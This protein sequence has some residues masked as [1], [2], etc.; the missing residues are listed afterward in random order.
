MSTTI[1]ETIS[2]T[3]PVI[4]DSKP[5]DGAAPKRRDL[6]TTIWHADEELHQK[7][8]AEKGGKEDMWQGGDIYYPNPPKI[9]VE[10]VIEDV[11]GREDQFTLK[12]NGFIFGK[13]YTKV[14]LKT[15]DLSDTK[16]IKEQYYPE[17][18]AWLKEVTGAPRVHVFHHGTRISSSTFHINKFDRN[19]PPQ[20]QPAVYAAHVDQ[21]SWQAKNVV[22]SHFPDECEALLH[23]RVMI[24]NAWR[25]IKP[26]YKDPFGVA[27]A[28]TVPY[29]DLVIRPNRVFKDIRE[30][31][32]LKPGKGH[33]WYY[34]F[35][36][37]PE[38]V[39]VFKGYDNHGKARACAH[40]AFVD[41]EFE[42]GPARESIELR[43]LLFWPDDESVLKE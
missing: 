4:S 38:D 21:S 13:Q 39:L 18:E 20:H 17:M 16:K 3:L 8:L 10:G 12:D 33:R 27:D 15:E 42:D 24:V 26:V 1:T 43:A 2:Q 23:G 19:A 7:Q 32:G 9:A 28:S 6:H 31:M 25:P 34:K 40:T 14:M 30:S 5:T 35:G 36:Q 37:L 11:S 41:K 29:Q 22:H